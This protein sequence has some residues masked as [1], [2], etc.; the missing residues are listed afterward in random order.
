MCRKSVFVLFCF[1]HASTYMTLHGK[2]YEDFFSLSLSVFYIRKEKY[3]SAT[4]TTATAVY[5]TLRGPPLDSEMGMEW[6][7]LVED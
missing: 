7:A 4:T 1:V 6:R 3:R 5:V 2:K